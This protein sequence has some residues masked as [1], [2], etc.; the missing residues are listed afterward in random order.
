MLIDTGSSVTI[1]N[2]SIFEKV[3]SSNEI[4][5]IP[6][7]LKFVT[8]TGEVCKFMGKAKLNMKIGHLELKHEILIADIENEGILGVDFLSQHNCDVLVSENCIQVD[9][10]KIKCDN[11]K[12]VNE[13]GV[14]RIFASEKVIIPP[15]T[16]M[17]ISGTVSSKTDSNSFGLVE[18]KPEFVERTGILVART[19]VDPN[20]NFV[21]VHV[22]NFSKDTCTIYPRTHLANCS[23][24]EPDKIFDTEN[25]TKISHEVKTCSITKNDHTNR[26][27]PP[28]LK[29]MLSE[30]ETCLNEE[31][32]MKSREFILKNANLFSK[33]D[34]DLGRTNIVE[35]TIDTGDSKPIKLPPYRIPLAK[36]LAAEKEIAKMAEQG[37]IE[38]STGP[39]SSPIL[40]VMKPDNTIR[41]C[42]DYRKLNS[43]TRKDSQPLPRIDDTLD[44]LAG[45]KWF[46]TLDLKSGFWQVGVAEKDRE[47]TAFSIHGSELWQFKVMPFGLCNSPATF[48]RL[49]EKVLS[50]LTWRKCLLFIDDIIVYSKTFDEHIENLDKVFE[51]LREAKLK[52]SPQKCVLFQKQVSFLGH[53]ISE[54]GVSTD[55]KKIQDVI[56][57]PTPKNVKEVRS[58]LG[59]C[60]YYRK[61]VENFSTIAKPMHKLTEKNVTF[62]WTP[63]CETAFEKLK[64][65]LVSS[66]ILSYPQNEGI[67][68][69]DTDASNVGMGAVLS[70]VQNEQEKV[71]CYFSKCFS[72][73]ERNYCVTRREL[74]AIVMAVKQ[75]HHYLL[76]RHF[77]IRSDHGALRWLLNFKK[78][79]GQIARWMEQLAMYDY[80]IQHRAG[81]IHN[82]ADSL[83]RR[84]CENCKYCERVDLKYENSDKETRTNSVVRVRLN[85]EDVMKGTRSVG[86]V[87]ENLQDGTGT[88]DNVA[89]VSCI[90][91]DSD[92][93]VILK[94]DLDEKLEHGDRNS[95]KEV[96]ISFEQ[97]KTGISNELP[98]LNQESGAECVKEIGVSSIAN[99]GHLTLVADHRIFPRDTNVKEASSEL[100]LN[101][102]SDL[103]SND[104]LNLD[105]NIESSSYQIQLYT[106]RSGKERDGIG[107]ISLSTVNLDLLKKLQRSDSVIGK[108]VTWK[109]QNVKPKWSDIAQYSVELKFYWNR[110]DSMVL[111]KEILYRKFESTNDK[112]YNLQIVLPKE[113]RN[114]VLKELH[115]SPTGGHL[116]VKKTI[117]RVKLR[118][119]WYGLS[120][121]V[122][123]WC[124]KCDICASRKMPSKKPKFSMKQYN[125]GA[126]IERVALDI[127]GPLP[128]SKRGNK[129]I[130]VACD[131]FTKWTEAW[132]MK[133]LEAKTVARKFVNH[134][135][136]KFGVPRQIHTDQGSNF[137]SQLF[138]EM[139]TVLGSEKTRTTAF[140]PQSDGLAERANRTIQNILSSYVNANQNDWDEFLP[141]VTMG[142]NSS[143]QASTGFSPSKMMYGREMTLPLDLIFGKPES[144]ALKYDTCYV[145][146]LSDNI[147][148]IHDIA[149]RKLKLSSDVQ[150]KSYDHK[151]YEN[152]YDE[153][154]LVW[155][156]DQNRGKNRKLNRPWKGPCKIIKR[157]ND[158]IYKIHLGGKSK[159]KIVH[160][161]R[162]K[163]YNGSN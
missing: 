93:T 91:V 70:Q 106:L 60:S 55:P 97:A 43:V 59:L 49:M 161:D 72:K 136:T 67:F 17:I 111:E 21:P 39:W 34:G 62:K 149:R 109:E 128:K 133:N 74:L 20:K 131:Y 29:I 154:D 78:P 107:Q 65:A 142:Y 92:K 113:M 81:K 28:H 69:L 7:N 118:F 89:G 143:V 47:K 124:K 148:Q 26:T 98:P 51:R 86:D 5:I 112:S 155:Y 10:E 6:I 77:V 153:G 66:P 129:Y 22:A 126:P 104:D 32:K 56:N 145:T 19:L 48:E 61:F 87:S 45:S 73:P 132:P 114:L 33:D 24:V 135:V 134:F 64:T 146:D 14:M 120:K 160:H 40:M 75:F 85:D 71:I 156:Y 147:D 157:L 83:S 115:D 121:D 130:L 31:Q 52:L 42:C 116:G 158:V 15:E 137:E 36:R 54:N 162:L 117:Q 80:S 16:E 96:V 100:N 76:G 44:A 151:I 27:I 105:S 84:P 94:C 9:G 138:K 1:I 150:K 18:G 140:R 103:D 144:E 41:F 152:R 23:E 11:R 4:D 50:R 53:T 25:D 82:N 102:N 159:P 101:S 95:N 90:N 63:E 38:P 12:C 79:E 8:A 46:S 125:V 99:I 68:I 127:V 122:E 141:L 3:K 123:K 2:K 35:H 88:S 13:I 163:P 37:I 57:W 30:S 58:F 110:L 108:I 119:F 139:C